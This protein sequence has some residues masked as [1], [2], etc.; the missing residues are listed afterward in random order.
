MSNT[1]IIVPRTPGPT[2]KEIV[3]RIIL[4]VDNAEISR[5]ELALSV[6]VK[7]FERGEENA[8]IDS[9]AM[10]LFFGLIACCFSFVAGLFFGG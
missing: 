2:S 4:E 3:E 10:W 5:R 6:G 7:A 8:K 9:S 1:I